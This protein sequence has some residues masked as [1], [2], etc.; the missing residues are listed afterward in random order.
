MHGTQHLSQL[1]A[2]RYATTVVQ[3]VV[4]A[5]APELSQPV[6]GLTLSTGYSGHGFGIGPGAGWATAQICT[7][8]TPDVSLDAL[9]LQRLRI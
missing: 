9:S 1:P 8:D 4:T 5:D 7:G 2:P 6:P 3:G